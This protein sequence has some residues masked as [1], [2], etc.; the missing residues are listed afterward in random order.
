[1]KKKRSQVYLQIRYC[2]HDNFYFPSTYHANISHMQ[3]TV[4]EHKY[5]YSERKCHQ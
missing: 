5:E 3:P 1:M 4:F 2:V